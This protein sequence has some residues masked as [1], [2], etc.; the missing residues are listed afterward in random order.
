[1]GGSQVF[2]LR[3]V[4]IQGKESGGFTIDLD[5]TKTYEGI[6]IILSF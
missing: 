6:E 2:S 3:S 5:V 1:M 4:L